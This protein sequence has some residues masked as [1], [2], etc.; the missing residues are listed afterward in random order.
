MISIIKV[1]K[2]KYK[3][4]KKNRDLI[5]ELA[6]ERGVSKEYIELSF[7]IF[8][9]HY[10]TS[11]IKKAVKDQV[12]LRKRMRSVY[13]PLNKQY[14]KT[15]P[16]GTKGKFWIKDDKLIRKLGVYVT[17]DKVVHIGFRGNPSYIKNKPKI[18]FKMILRYLEYGT[19]KIPA[20]PL[21]RPILKS[22]RKNI[23]WLWFKFVKATK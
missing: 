10:I 11:R 4:L 12:I 20:R 8:V 13:K 19:N 16:Y 9:A 7:N 21:I 6:L 2:E 22:T 3:P 14:R 17:N 18:K 15:K 1:A 5:E 23:N